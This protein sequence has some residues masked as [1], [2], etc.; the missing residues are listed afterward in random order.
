MNSLK[1]LFLICSLNVSVFNSQSLVYDD[2]VY[3]D[4]I[5][6]PMCYLE[7]DMLSAPY[8]ELESGRLKVRFDDISDEIK[9]YYYTVIHCDYQWNPSD[10]DKLDYMTGFFENTI[11]ESEGSFNTQTDYIHYQFSFPNDMTGVS[12][13]GN[14]LM[15]VYEDGDE[16]NVIISRR[17]VVYEQLVNIDTHLKEAT[18]ISD[19]RFRQEI[20]VKVFFPNYAID[21][22]YSDFHL[23]IMQNNRWDN[24]ITNLQPRFVKS[25][26]LN[27]DYNEENVFDGGNEFREFNLSKLQMATNQVARTELTEGRWTAYLRTDP[28]RSYKHYITNKDINGNFYIVNKDGFEQHVEEEYVWVRFSLKQDYRTNT[29]IYIFGKMTDWQCKNEFLMKYN[30]E[31]KVYTNTVL[32]K[33][34]YYNYVYAIYDENQ[35]DITSIEGTHFDTENEYTVIAYNTDFVAGYDRVVGVTKTNSFNR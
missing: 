21:N 7:G 18:N 23:T 8:I 15:V 9:D 33:Q 13:S 14:Y 30:S 4:N 24:A 31:N 20:D 27:Y 22:P 1:F 34:G 26:E 6:T 17:F 29:P 12:I 10:L 28:S 32:L 3:K 2:F 19:S 25:G 16:E 35:I 11:T 5:K